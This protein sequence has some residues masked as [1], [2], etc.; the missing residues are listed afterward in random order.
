MSLPAGRAEELNGSKCL[1]RNEA[2]QRGLMLVND[3]NTAV[4]DSNYI[5]A[6]PNGSWQRLIL[7]AAG[8]GK[9]ANPS[10]V[11]IT[12]N[13][14]TNGAEKRIRYLQTGAGLNPPAIL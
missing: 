6:R 1:R 10:G 11:S 13:I 5:D 12:N 2:T 3:S 14:P 8:G 4:P 7:V 9:F